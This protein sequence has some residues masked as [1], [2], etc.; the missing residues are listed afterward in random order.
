VSLKIRYIALPLSRGCSNIQLCHLEL[1]GTLMWSSVNTF[2]N[3]LHNK[4]QMES[5]LKTT[6]T[7]TFPPS[8]SYDHTNIQCFVL[9]QFNNHTTNRSPQT[10]HTNKVLKI[11]NMTR[12]VGWLEFNVPFQH[13]YGNIRDEINMTN[14]LLF[15]DKKDIW[16]M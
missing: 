10:A 4:Q 6:S 8:P 15:G 9:E 3:N 5:L 12:L 13:K 14:T 11:I 2:Y 7:T 16:P 1:T